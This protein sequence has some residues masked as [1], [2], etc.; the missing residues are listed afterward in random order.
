MSALIDFDHL[1]ASEAVEHLRNAFTNTFR[2]KSTVGSLPEDADVWDDFLFEEHSAGNHDEVSCMTSNRRQR[3]ERHHR[4]CDRRGR[5]NARTCAAAE[6]KA[7]SHRSA[8]SA[9]AMRCWSSI[10]AAMVQQVG[11]SESQRGMR[12]PWAG[13]WHHPSSS[14]LAAERQQLM[15]GHERWLRS[16]LLE[17]N[18]RCE[19]RNLDVTKSRIHVHLCEHHL[20]PEAE[21]CN[22][23]PLECK[24][25][26]KDCIRLVIVF[27]GATAVTKTVAMS[28]PL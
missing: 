1:E 23:S 27:A 19:H 2:L 4:I 22:V 7:K 20:P 10:V 24:E 8:R 28:Y 11:S 3:R 6:A 18:S 14:P 17:E 13:M 9:R 21:R 15:P 16:P 5:R 25:E 12:L 26:R